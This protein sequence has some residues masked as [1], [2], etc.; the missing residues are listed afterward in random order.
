[1]R[2]T[3]FLFFRL[4]VRKLTDVQY[5]D[6]FVEFF[7][8]YEDAAETVYIAMEYIADGDLH[9][10]MLDD[11]A[12]A[13]GCWKIISTQILTAFNILHKNKICHRDLKPQVYPFIPQYI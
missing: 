1:M 11:R 4:L 10:Y 13:K 7:G 2:W 6:S 12:R 3:P 9:A 5:T 8:W